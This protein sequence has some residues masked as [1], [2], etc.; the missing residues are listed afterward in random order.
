[1]N[2]TYTQ[3]S[4]GKPMITPHVKHEIASQVAMA[5]PA[6]TAA[7]TTLVLG[8]T[9]NEVLAVASIAFIALQAAYLIWKWRREAKRK[10]VNV[11]ASA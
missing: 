4:S 2:H 11:D 7:T 10:P 5:A 8:L 1:M 6:V 3:P 9:L